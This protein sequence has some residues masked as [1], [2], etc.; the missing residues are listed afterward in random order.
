MN[1]LSPPSHVISTEALP[2]IHASP[3]MET[4]PKRE[5]ETRKRK[6]KQILL[7]HVL[8]NVTTD[9]QPSLSSSSLSV[10][11]LWWFERIRTFKAPTTALRSS[12]ALEAALWGG[13]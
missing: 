7:Q 3:N 9:S 12:A 10:I 2:S 6:Q 13:P 4:K 11:M 8:K 1:G 5:T